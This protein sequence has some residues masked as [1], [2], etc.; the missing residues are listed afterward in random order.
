MHL[1]IAKV[2]LRSERCLPHHTSDNFLIVFGIFWLSH[3]T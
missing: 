3:I 1:V 2:T